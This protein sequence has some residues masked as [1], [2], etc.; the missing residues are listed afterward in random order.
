MRLAGKNQC[1]LSDRA[2]SGRGNVD[3]IVI[4][5]AFIS[6]HARFSPAVVTAAFPQSTDD[7][8]GRQMIVLVKP[9]FEVGREL[10]G[11]GRDRARRGCAVGGGGKGEAGVCWRSRL[12]ER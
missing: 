7:R 1:P 2:K 9:Q 4:D 12:H 11:K 6:G 10:V 8:R 3:L 5:V